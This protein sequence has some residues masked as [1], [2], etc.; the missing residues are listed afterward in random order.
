MADSSIHRGWRYDRDNDRLDLVYE[1]TTAGWIDSNGLSTETGI[2]VA[3]GGTVTQ[4]TSRSTG[5]TLNTLSGVITMNA[6]SLAAAAEATFTVTN[7][8]VAATDVVIVC[9]SSGLTTGVPMV[10]VS[11]VAAGSF[12]I[13]ITNLDAA[14]ADTTADTINFVVIKGSSS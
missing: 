7:S 4:A 3:D 2:T 14:T 12:D 6:A 10:Y 13:T 11:D 1:T 9:L 5:V 8:K